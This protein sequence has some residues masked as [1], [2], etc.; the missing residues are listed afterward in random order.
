M[1]NIGDLSADGYGIMIFSPYI[2]NEY[3]KLKKC[4]AKKFLSYFDKNKEFFYQ[5]IKDGKI[6]PL[7]QLASFEYDL[8]VSMDEEKEDIPKEYLKVYEYKGFFI[9]VGIDEK[10]CF[11]N[12]DFMEYEGESIKKGI[13]KKSELIP[14]G[15][16][17]ILEN[18]NSA[19]EL[20]IEKGKYALDIIGLKRKNKLERESKNFAYLFR[21]TKKTIANE[22]FIK[23]DN[24]TCTFDIIQNEKTTTNNV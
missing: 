13:T 2:F 11:A 17:E 15:A 3:L 20:E 7:Y 23:A 16:E 9:E 18:Y 21:F 12:F 6:L 8:F 5:T 4:R 1:K 24:D 14:T 10:L 22:N 19:L